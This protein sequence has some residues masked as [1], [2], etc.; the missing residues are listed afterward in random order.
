M[1]RI[2]WWPQLWL[3][4]VFGSGA[5]VGFA[6]ANGAMFESGW[7]N[8]VTA[9]LLLYG[10]A[11]AWVVGYDTI[12]ALQDREDDALV[13]IRSSA[14]RLG[15]QVRFGVAI[16]YL[17]ALGFWGAAFWQVRPDLLAL[18]ALLPVALHLGW[19]VA[20]LAPDDGDN[21]LARFRSNRF[22]GFLMFLACLVVGV[23]S[24]L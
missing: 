10:G 2:T 9:M 19:Q 12:Y 6:A 5:V 8:L 17:A 21:A 14:R 4:L 22:A 7:W 13:G 11:I 18:V 23:S 3:G 16:F 20:T 1:K 15:G 24:T